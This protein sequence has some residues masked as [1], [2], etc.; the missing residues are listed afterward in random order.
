MRFLTGKPEIKHISNIPSIKFNGGNPVCTCNQ[1][2]IIIDRVYY[3]DDV[4]EYRLIDGSNPPLYCENCK[5][6]VK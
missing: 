3:K 2:S 6:K 5:E 1:C 4:K